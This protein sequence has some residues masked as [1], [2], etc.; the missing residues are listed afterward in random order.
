MLRRGQDIL[1]RFGPWALAGLSSLVLAGLILTTFPTPPMRMLF[2]GLLFP[3]TFGF[4]LVILRAV[5]SHR[6]PATVLARDPNRLMRESLM[7]AGF[8][9]ICAWLRMIRVLSLAN[10]LLLLGV[11]IFIEAFLVSRVE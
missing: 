1:I 8:L 2:L 7:T 10:A 3:S 11:L 4:A 5:Y 6:L 9:T